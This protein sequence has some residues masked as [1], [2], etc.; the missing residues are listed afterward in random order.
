MKRVCAWCNKFMG[1]VD[2]GEDS[3]DLI[4]HTICNECADNLDFQ[5]GV[6]LQRYLDSFK[7][8]IIAVDRNGNMLAVN[9]PAKGLNGI[10]HCNSGSGWDGKIYECA[11]SRLPERCSNKFHFNGCAIR[12]AVI[13]T[14]NTGNSHIDLPTYINDHY[15]QA[16]GREYD[17]LISASKKNGTVYLTIDPA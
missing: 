10:E 2:T 3:S 12:F 4:T 6:T 13:D 14:F 15:P 5:L 7:I 17:L 16:L 9:K 1:S 11:H 8:P